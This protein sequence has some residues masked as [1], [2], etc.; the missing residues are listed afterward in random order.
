MTRT[1]SF[2]LVLSALA[3]AACSGPTVDSDAGTDGGAQPDAGT[4]TP[5]SGPTPDAGPPPD[6]GPTGCTVGCNFVELALGSDHTCARREN[7]EVWCWG[8]DLE[9]QLGDGAPRH[10]SCGVDMGVPIDCSSTPVQVRAIE[11]GRP[12]PVTDA[13]QISSE[14]GLST[15]MVRESGEVWC[16]GLEGIARV[17]GAML[18]HRFAAQRI[19]D[20]GDVGHVSDGWLHTCMTQGPDGHVV[21]FGYNESGQLGV[22][23]RM[24]IRIP[25]EARPVLDPSDATMALSG[26]VEVAV[27]GFSD[28]TCA[29]TADRVYCWGTNRDG[30]LGD[31]STSHDA[32]QCMPSMTASYDCTSTPVVVGGGDTP[33]ANVGQITAGVAHVCALGSGDDAGR[34]WCWGDNRGGQLAQPDT[35]ST[36]NVAIE[37]TGLGEVAQID[38]ASRQTCARQTDGTV[39][40]WGFNLRGQ[41]GDGLMDHSTTCTFGSTSGDC[42]RTP[43]QVMGIDD[44]TVIGVGN[45]H[46]CA[47]RAGGTAVSCWGYNDTS[48]LGDRTR[49]TRY[50]P[51]NVVGLPD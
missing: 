39:W 1:A 17:N 31:G 9:G 51:V 48:Q 47:I 19:E 46:A 5:D 44:A 49:D 6:A 16:W 4:P 11:S 8:R 32:T 41:L 26:A 33:L 40:C 38:A 2:A 28:T 21:C 15:C 50:A 14:G 36:S 13:V 42:S 37:I 22:G 30:Q 10:D 24:E 20:F 18:E 45:S 43:V 23:D 27:G 7:G 12:V 34:V 35:V 3:F 29:R 25:N